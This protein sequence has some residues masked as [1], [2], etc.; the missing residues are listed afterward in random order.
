MNQE[1]S[2]AIRFFSR[3][4][5][6]GPEVDDPEVDGHPQQIPGRDR[7]NNLS[8]SLDDS[9]SGEESAQRNLSKPHF[10]RLFLTDSDVAGRGAAFENRCEA[11]VAWRK[12]FQ[13]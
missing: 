2:S 7:P 1:P 6:F 12:G 4:P 13:G 5:K 9:G 10:L 3:T 8:A 11:I